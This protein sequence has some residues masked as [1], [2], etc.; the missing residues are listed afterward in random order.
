MSKPT[1]SI[2]DCDRPKKARGFCQKHYLRWREE[3]PDREGPSCAIEGC[4][5]NVLA[6]GWCNTHYHRWHRHG[7]PLYVTPWSPPPQNRPRTIGCSVEGCE[8]KHSAKGMCKNHYQRVY[9]AKNA[10]RIKAQQAEYRSRPENRA[11]AIETAR[12][13]RKANPERAREA[14]KR[15]A[16]E[17]ADRVREYKREYRAANRDAIRAL[18][19][20][21]KAMHRAVEI[22]DLTSDE[23]VEIIAAHDGR[24]VYC[25]EKPERITMDHVV[26][27]SKGGN[28]TAS[29]VVPACGPCNSAKSANEPPPFVVAP[30]LPLPA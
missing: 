22:N 16:R 25:G 2:D 7:D 6:R 26:P 12:E 15:W 20:R 27:I 17:N 1:C 4:G 13:W 28:H 30:M 29:N 21:R 18:N 9:A 23:W 10:D 14:G 11:K 3:S 24:C 5:K 8:A 19:N